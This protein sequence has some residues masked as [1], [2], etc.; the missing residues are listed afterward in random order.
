[1]TSTAAPR[2]RLTG[3]GRA[4]VLLALVGLLLAAVSLGRS[5][6]TQAATSPAPRPVPVQA[7]IRPGDTLWD[8]ARRIAPGSDPR[9]VVAQIRRMNDLSG[10]A[11][12]V[13]QQ[14]L[15]PAPQ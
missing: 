14:I 12:Q 10:S 15:L 1:M 7:V 4:V 3:R 8:V 9:E 6:A 2:T 13:G 11:V 5:A